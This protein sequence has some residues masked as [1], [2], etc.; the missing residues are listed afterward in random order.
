MQILRH[1]RIALTMEISTQVPDAATRAAVRQL[2]DALDQG[3]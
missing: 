2:S 1:S 3:D